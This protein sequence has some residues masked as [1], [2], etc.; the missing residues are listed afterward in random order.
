MNILR[1]GEKAEAH[2]T[3][4]PNR[5]KTRIQRRLFLRLVIGGILISAILSVV[6]YTSERQRISGEVIERANHG[7]QR[8]NEQIASILNSPGLSE[9]ANLQTKLNILFIAAS[10]LQETGRFVFIGIYDPE[11]L[12]IASVMDQDYPR[13]VQVQAMADGAPRSA[14]TRS[15][16]VAAIRSIDGAP[17]I[18]MSFPLINTKGNVAAY[19]EAVYAV[20]AETV[21]EVEKQILQAI[22][23]VIAIVMGTT[24]LLYPLIALLMSRQARLAAGLLEANLET[25]RVLGSAVAKRDS[26]TD[27]HNYRVTIY[28]VRLAEAL[29]LDAP[30]IRGLIKGAFLH[31]VGK[32][33]VSDTILLNPGS[34]TD[35]EYNL[36]KQ[37][38]RHGLDII[39]SSAWL[40][41]AADVVGYHHEWYKGGGYPFGLRGDNIPLN[42]RIFAIADV[43]DA[44]TSKRPYKESYDLE[45]TLALMND[46]RDVHFDPEIL[47]DF[48]VIAEILYRELTFA[49]EAELRKAL[50]AII[51]K[52]FNDDI[53]A[54]FFS[55]A[56]RKRKCSIPLFRHLFRSRP[57]KLSC[58]QK[59]EHEPVAYG[60]LQ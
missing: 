26:E 25:L 28:A 45:K 11:N 2:R 50:D 3:P 55:S 60:S 59:Q 54:L 5:L 20:S 21:R 49:G 24:L 33:G 48:F 29:N 13:A 4:G 57:A 51:R 34:L 14:L 40:I 30:A 17:H 1:S 32:I 16:P 39:N 53:T 7:A 23:M 58:R 15:R 10:R 42:A 12:A 56:K 31:D 38:V 52:Y 35:S 46:M 8:F 9:K 47:D 6:V 22:L 43:F 27:L 41:D 37:H 18:Y 44:L 19:G 36:M